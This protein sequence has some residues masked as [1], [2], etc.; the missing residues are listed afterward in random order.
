MG[1]WLEMLETESPDNAAD[2]KGNTHST[3][4]IVIPVNP[5]TGIELDEPAIMQAMEQACIG[6]AILPQEF[7]AVI[8]DDEAMWCATGRIPAKTARAYARLFA[9][10]LA[11]DPA[12][13]SSHG[14][15][16]CWACRHYRARRC[17][18]SSTASPDQWI[19]CSDYRGVR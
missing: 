1:K 15:V 14:K 6:L 9:Q 10:Q 5:A 13:P 18:R 7:R 17:L 12:H 19:E 4:A 11:Q 2:T 16:T 8:D 3:G